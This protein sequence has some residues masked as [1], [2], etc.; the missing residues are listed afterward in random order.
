MFQSWYFESLEGVED[1]DTEFAV[2]HG[3]MLA[4]HLETQK[5][6]SEIR[7]WS[8]PPKKKHSKKKT[9]GCFLF[10]WP[11]NYLKFHGLFFLGFSSRKLSGVAKHLS[12]R[13]CG[14]RFV[15]DW[16]GVGA[17]ETQFL[18]ATNGVNLRET[19]VIWP[20]ISWE[21]WH[22]WGPLRFPWC[23]LLFV[24]HLSLLFF[25]CCEMKTVELGEKI[26]WKK[27]HHGCIYFATSCRRFISGRFDQAA[28]NR[29]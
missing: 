6:G 15:F 26:G 1:A 20:A 27:S 19:N 24:F 13:S 7:H 9:L 23:Q 5:I 10:M 28:D 21:R 12:T 17:G 2:H 29:N 14:G 8:P 4:S 11:Q 22:W 18:S 16:Q 3:V 25:R